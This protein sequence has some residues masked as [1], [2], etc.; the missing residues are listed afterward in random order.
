MDEEIFAKIQTCHPLDKVQNAIQSGR[1]ENDKQT[2]TTGTE[3]RYS[4]KNVQA[5]GCQNLVPIY[6]IIRRTEEENVARAIT[7]CNPKLRSNRRA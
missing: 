5:Y 4:H 1:R 2:R 3:K 6:L 7:D